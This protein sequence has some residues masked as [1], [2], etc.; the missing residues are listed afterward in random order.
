MQSH[1]RID[2]VRLFWVDLL[3]HPEEIVIILQ[4]LI[5][6]EPKVTQFIV[7]EPIETQLGLKRL[8]GPPLCFHT[9]LPH[10]MVANQHHH[11]IQFV[12]AE[13]RSQRPRTAAGRPGRNL[14]TLGR[15]RSVVRV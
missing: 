7:G 11:T 4:E 3:D 2:A 8:Q 12:L 5:L 14:A 1:A 13:T 6:L 10:H 15:W 9:S